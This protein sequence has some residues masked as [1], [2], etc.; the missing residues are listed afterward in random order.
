L[1]LFAGFPIYGQSVNSEVGEAKPI[2]D[3]IIKFITITG[4]VSRGEPLA[5][6]V[7][8][9]KGAEKNTA[10]TDK[11]GNFS[12]NIPFEHFT[13]KVFLRFEVLGKK[14]LEKQVSATTTNLK[15]HYDPDKGPKRK[16]QL[17]ATYTESNVDSRETSEIITNELGKLATSALRN[18][19]ER[20]SR[21]SD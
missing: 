18:A 4:T 16:W 2:K 17:R 15:V 20:Q 7:V 14:P 11:D 3:S 9:E 12:I 10:V 13:D 21:K 6:I 1:S 5:D 19:S 8:I